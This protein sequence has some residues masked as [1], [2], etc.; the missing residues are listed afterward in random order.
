MSA[1]IK[2]YLHVKKNVL[3][4]TRWGNTF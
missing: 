3:I 4:I 2:S 1:V